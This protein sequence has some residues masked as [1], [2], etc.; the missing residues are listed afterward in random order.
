MAAR[1]QP[2]Q[3]S[4]HSHCACRHDA[5]WGW[6]SSAHLLWRLR[7]LLRLLGKLGSALALLLQAEH[8]R[9]CQGHVGRSAG[10][11]RLPCRPL[12][13]PLACEYECP[14][15]ARRQPCCQ[16]RRPGG[17]RLP[18]P[19]RP[20]GLPA[21]K[22]ARR[23]VHL[24]C[25][26]QAH[27]LVAHLKVGG[28]GCCVGRVDRGGGCLGAQR[29][30]HLPH[31]HGRIGDHAG[32]RLP[33]SHGMCSGK[34]HPLMAELPALSEPRR[35]GQTHVSCSQTV[36]IACPVGQAAHLVTRH[37]PASASSCCRLCCA[38]WACGPLLHLAASAA[39]RWASRCASASARHSTS[40]PR[41][42]AAA[43]DAR[44]MAGLPVSRRRRLECCSCWRR[45]PHQAA[46]MPAR[47]TCRRLECGQVPRGCT[48][49]RPTAWTELLAGE[50]VLLGLCALPLDAC[51]QRHNG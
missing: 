12:H 49:G 9:S 39:C 42:Q 47:P 8:S 45:Q 14:V 50:D 26:T 17:P 7:R 48:A 41:C 40:T 28:G 22:Q 34:P 5:G 13:G 1:P 31:V 23:P 37:R 24:V 35:T 11:G 43:R 38:C 46:V 20:A 21:T 16:W 30:Q 6:Q 25:N 36:P 44:C 27:A 15:W 51:R 3:A 33:G 19:G 2:S 29:L 32:A 4:T 10:A 18:G